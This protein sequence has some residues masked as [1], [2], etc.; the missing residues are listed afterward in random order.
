MEVG[1]VIIENGLVHTRT[2]PFSSEKILVWCGDTADN[3]R[4]TLLHRSDPIV[5]FTVES[6]VIDFDPSV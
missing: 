5:E 6:P 3:G 1:R 2:S 4:Q